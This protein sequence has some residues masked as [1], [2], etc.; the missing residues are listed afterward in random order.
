LLRGLLLRR[1]IVLIAIGAITAV[2]ILG[3]VRLRFDSSIEIWFLDNDPSLVTYRSFL[4]RFA[5]DEVA[6][7]GVFA[8]D[9]FDPQVLRGVKQLGRALEKAPHALRVRSLAT[10]K[11]FDNTDDE[12]LKIAPVYSE[13]PKSDAE[14]K[15]LRGKT[16]QNKL[17][18][19]TL[20]S[21]DGRATAIIVEMKA[22]RDG[23]RAKR[24]LTAAMKKA[25]AAHPIPGARM[26]IAG[27]PAL[28]AAFEH[29]S[30]RDATLLGPVAL[31]VLLLAALLLYRRFSAAALMLTVVG[32]ATVWTF[33]LMG[34]L[35]IDLNVVSVALVV[36][37]MAVGVADSI[38]VLSDYYRQLAEGKAV[39]GA[40]QASLES[41]LM[42]CFFTSATTMAGMLSLALSSLAP[43]R[44]FGYLA[45]A[46]VGIA[47]LLSFTFL[48]AALS[49]FRPPDAAFIERQ[50]RGIVSRLLSRL[51]RPSPRWRHAVLLVAM[52]LAGLGALGLSR[53][54]IGT[55]PMT[56]FKRGDPIRVATTEIDRRLGGSVTLEFLVETKRDGLK[57][58]VVLKRLEAFQAWAEKRPGVT[59]VLSIVDTLKELRR[60]LGDGKPEAAKLPTSRQMAAQLYL[61]LEGEA[62]FRRELQ[63]GYSVTRITARAMLSDAGKL[64]ADTP[65]LE[66]KLA[67]ELSGD[68]LRVRVTGFVKLMSDMESYLLNSQIKSFALAFCVVTLMMLALLRSVGLAA[69]SL[70]PNLLPIALGLGF[71]G[72]VGISLDPGTVMIGSIALGLVVDDTVHFLVRLRRNLQAGA[73]LE[74]GI[75]ETM[76]ET[77]RPIVVTSLILAACFLVLGLGSFNPNVNFGLVTALV[78]IL[79]LVADLIILPAVVLGARPRLVRRS[80]DSES[81]EG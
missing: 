38:H 11:V 3:A 23:M 47:F 69:L 77:G 21:P 17:L 10:V 15:A 56:Y 35:G 44:E 28:D 75:D 61:L 9:V 58:P 1:V 50:Q 49:L 18:R 80:A 72:M 43:L 26:A 81:P 48:P 8:D 60:V 66:A 70:I 19:G 33:G 40:V 63:R 41:Q 37:T 34:W 22:A 27:T 79:A 55:N 65:R 74:H 6:V 30:T 46:A 31:A 13:A 32:L 51:A 71:M 12:G 36:L 4:K 5:A 39:E 7:V 76:Q 54:T 78:V 53:L 29:H 62:D 59:R 64:T 57:D 42:P 14:R 25:L 52:I 67:R 68:D 2:A 73:S 24:E 16:L 45:A 20:V